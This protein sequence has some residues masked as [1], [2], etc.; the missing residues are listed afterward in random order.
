MILLCVS[1]ASRK[2]EKVFSVCVR[3]GS[4]LPCRPPI[5][6]TTQPTHILPTTHTL[7]NLTA[8]RQRST[9]R[10]P[11]SRV[12][13]HRL[14]FLIIVGRYRD[15][16]PTPDHACE[17]AASAQDHHEVRRHSTHTSQSCKSCMQC[18]MP[19]DNNIPQKPTTPCASAHRGCD[20]SRLRPLV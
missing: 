2:C 19:C 17:Q 15:S 4:G 14:P 10:T 7:Y 1:Y 5:R 3:G 18:Q 12:P 9:Q 8:R 16:Q 20:A 6:V 13:S 11:A